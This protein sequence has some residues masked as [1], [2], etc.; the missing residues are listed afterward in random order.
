MS[1]SPYLAMLRSHVGHDLLLVPAVAAIVK[2]EGG[3]VLFV[4][5]VEDGRWGLPA[6]AVDPGESPAGAVVRE[7]REETGLE[8]EVVGVVGVFGGGG[9]SGPVC[10]WGFDGVCDDRF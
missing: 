9:D 7:V 1:I 8:V 5:G 6:R 3:E 10:E 2:N 4:W